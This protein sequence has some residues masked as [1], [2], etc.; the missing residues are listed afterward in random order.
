MLNGM[1]LTRAAAESERKVVSKMADMMGDFAWIAVG[2]ML[3][4]VIAVWAVKR[5]AKVVE[6]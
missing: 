3:L 2:G 5:R 6:S 4:Q 1:R